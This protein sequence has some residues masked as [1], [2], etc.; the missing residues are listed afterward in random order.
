M[1]CCLTLLL[2]GQDDQWQFSLGTNL[3]GIEIDWIARFRLP[4][5]ESHV[6]F[7]GNK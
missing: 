1:S 4:T 2:K 5:D 6:T 3:R 7:P